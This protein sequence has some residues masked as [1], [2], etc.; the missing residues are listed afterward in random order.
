MLSGQRDKVQEDKER[1]PQ[2]VT[3]GQ[4]DADGF[5]GAPASTLSTLGSP[6]VRMGL[7]S[8]PSE[9]R[10]RWWNLGR[11][12]VGDI[13]VGA[14]IP[15]AADITI[16]PPTASR[17]TQG[18]P[19]ADNLPTTGAEIP[20]YELSSTP[21]PSGTIAPSWGALEVSRSATLGTRAL[22]GRGGRAPERAKNMEGAG[23]TVP[24]E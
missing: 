18:I 4:V 17:P 9:K 19:R 23:K 11:G 6:L 15:D 3:S 20:L 12:V 16:S 21:V 24:V 5:T 1:I 8:T 22:N 14:G 13:E 10:P 7:R 2:M